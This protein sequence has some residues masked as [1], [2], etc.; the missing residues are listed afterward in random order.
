M[1]TDIHRAPTDARHATFVVDCNSHSYGLGWENWRRGHGRGRGVKGGGGAGERRTQRK[2]REKGTSTR[3]GRGGGGGEGREAGRSLPSSAS[4]SSSTP[5]S[6]H[7]L[8]WA[9]DFMCLVRFPG[10]KR[11]WTQAWLEGGARQA[12]GMSRQCLVGRPWL[13]T[14]TETLPAAG[15]GRG[16]DIPLPRYSGWAVR[17][18]PP[19]KAVNGSWGWVGVL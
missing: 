10:K 12:W 19:C 3:A 11:E 17:P 13:L 1:S 14:P 2:G 5:V 7:F 18:Q 8:L 9:F 6:W 4:S 15:L 16:P